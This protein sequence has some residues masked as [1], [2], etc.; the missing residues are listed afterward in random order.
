VMPR[1]FRG[2]LVPAPWA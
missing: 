2:I 1:A